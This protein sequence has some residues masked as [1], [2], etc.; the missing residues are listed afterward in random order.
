MAPGYF[1]AK[2]PFPR[3]ST[4]SFDLTSALNQIKPQKRTAT[5]ARRNDA[6]LSFA[7]D[8]FIVGGPLLYDTTVYIDIFHA[9]AP[10]A[11]KNL[12][13]MR[14]CE[15]SAICLSELTHAFGRLD[16][17]HPDTKKSLA[18]IKGAID[19][20]PPHRLHAPTAKTWGEAGILAGALIR[21]V[22]TSANQGQERKFLNDALIYL[23]AQ[24]LG[25]TILTRNIRD[26]DFLSQIAPGSRVLFY[27]KA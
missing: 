26:F 6:D 1:V 19:D 16:P 24:T 10:S 18:A 2:A 15:H 5:L 13:A 11:V 17:R 4:L 21:L 3:A 12:I 23:Q 14:I 9:N 27:R 25:A 7:D 20:I 22:G 8:D